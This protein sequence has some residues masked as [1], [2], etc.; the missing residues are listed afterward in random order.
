MSGKKMRWC[1]QGNRLLRGGGEIHLEYMQSVS[2][3]EKIAIWYQ[4][5]Q[6]KRPPKIPVPEDKKKEE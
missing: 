2:S 4:K 5:E 3:Q 1:L 6:K